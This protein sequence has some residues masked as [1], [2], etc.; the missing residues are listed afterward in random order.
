VGFD[1][2]EQ[3]NSPTYRRSAG[4]GLYER[5]SAEDN[6]EF[7]GGLAHQLPK[8]DRIKELLSNL[9]LSVATMRCRVVEPGHEAEAGGS[10]RYAPLSTF[11][12][13]G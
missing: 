9:G 4:T 2:P 13:S 8:G 11:D 12:L 10:S 5:L 6:L 3:I 7:T 1:T